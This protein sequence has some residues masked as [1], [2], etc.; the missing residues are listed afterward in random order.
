MF[1][2]INNKRNSIDVDKWDYIKRD[3]Y[4]MNLSLGQFDYSILLEDARVIDDEI[5]YP[6]KHAY[7]VMKL[8]QARYELYKSIYNHLTVHSIE[9]ILCDVLMAAHKVLYNFEEAIWDPETYT[10]MTDNIIYEIQVSKDPRLLPAKELIKKLQRRDFYPYVGEVIFGSETKSTGSGPKGKELFN[11]ITEKD[12]IACAKQDGYGLVLREEDIA[13]RK[14]KLNFAQGDKSP[15]ENVKFY[16]SPQ[17]D[18]ADY[19]DQHSVS[20][21]TPSIFQEHVMRLFVKDPAKYDIAQNAFKKLA[22]DVIG[23]EDI[24]L[25]KSQSNNSQAL[26]RAHEQSLNQNAVTLSQQQLDL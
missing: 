12:V 18:K 22:R 4:M 26:R 23:V 7:E 6:H 10:Q 8:F 17:F 20:L 15:F 19:V 1:D 11:R 24:I 5:V 3:T 21:I 16:H 2:I 13:L 25:A 9:I 14:Y